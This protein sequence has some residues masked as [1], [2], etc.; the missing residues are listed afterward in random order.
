M[1]DTIT[2]RVPEYTEAKP[3]RKTTPGALALR[4][5]IMAL[6]LGVVIGGIVWFNHIRPAMIAGFMA[7]NRPPP[8]PVQAAEATLA[9]IPQSLPAIGSLSA[10]RQVTVAAEI[11]GRV[12]QIAFESG[13]HVRAGDPLVQLYDKPEQGDLANF[14]A[15]AKLGQVSLL[16]AR[17][18][19]NRNVGSQAAVDQAQAQLDQAQAGIAKTQALIAQKLIRTPFEGDLGVRQVELGQFLAAGAPIVTLTDLSVLYINLTVP[20]Q[21][22]S[23]VAVG[24]TVRVRVDAFPDEVFEG[25]VN[26]V[27]PQVGADMRMIKAQATMTNPGKRLLPGM[28]AKIEIVLPPVPDV[29]VVPE[30]ALDY[31]LYGNSVFVLK[32]DE[33]GAKDKEG[34]PLFKAVRT[35]V[36]AGE[37]SD[38]GVA[39]LQG[40]NPGDR[41]VASGQHK[42]VDNMPVV[43]S[44]EPPLA[45]PATMPVN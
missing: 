35:F 24:Q 6:L 26:A 37:R 17:E 3:R 33:G 16:R 38:A 32:A 29:V 25:T 1:P 19:A 13:Q 27:E 45:P 34:H 14:Q 7:A 40:L 20:E 28:F 4:M 41:V 8:P 5:T 15:Q 11:G 21:N 39:I 23:R 18:L 12:V 10:V 44:P 31:T 30:T 2:E 36:K 43:I 9:S 42:L 22:R